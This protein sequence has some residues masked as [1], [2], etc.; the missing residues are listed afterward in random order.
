M[1]VLTVGLLGSHCEGAIS[2]KNETNVD[3]DW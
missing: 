3:V 1:I 2:C